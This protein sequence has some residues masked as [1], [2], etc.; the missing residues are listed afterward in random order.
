MDNNQNKISNPK[1]EVSK[2]MKLNDKDY[3]TCL[4]LTLKCMEKNYA[5]ALTEASN[6]SLYQ[7]YYQTFERISNFQRKVYETMFQK[8]WYCLEKAESNKI[9]EKLNMLNQELT[10]LNR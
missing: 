5:I 9:T 4:I 8:G 10:D 7:K 6:E 1:T 2:G 3:I